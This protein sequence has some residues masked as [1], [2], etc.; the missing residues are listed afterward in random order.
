[1]AKSIFLFLDI[2]SNIYDIFNMDSMNKA[3]NIF[4]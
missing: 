4:Q 1:M 2:F 3:L